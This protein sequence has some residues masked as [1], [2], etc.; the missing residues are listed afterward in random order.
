MLNL[1]RYSF[2]L[3]LIWQPIWFLLLQP[4][5]T[6]SPVAVLGT[7]MIPLAILLPL[8]WRLNLHGLIIGGCIL[9]VYF[10]FAVMELWTTPAARIGAG[11][12]TLLTV[13]YFTGILVGFRRQQQM[14]MARFRNK[15]DSD[16]SK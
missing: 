14:R 13:A 10:S 15:E 16:G 8:V 12:Q 2:V 3:L 5:E 1:C 4:L 9:L 11:V 7:T 6:F